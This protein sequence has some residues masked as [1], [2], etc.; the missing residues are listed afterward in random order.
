MS[1]LGQSIPDIRRGSSRRNRGESPPLAA[2]SARSLQE[3]S[4]GQTAILNGGARWNR[5]SDL[6]IIRP[7]RPDR[8]TCL[9]VRKTC[10]GVVS[11]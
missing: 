5:T 10:S 7:P 2:P 11:V 6:S 8:L 1:P 9:Y 4:A 3:E